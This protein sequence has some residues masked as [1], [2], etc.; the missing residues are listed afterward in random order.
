MK[1]VTKYR[2][3]TLMCEF[4]LPVIFLR[5]SPNGFLPGFGLDFGFEC[6]LA[7]EVILEPFLLFS[8][9]TIFRRNIFIKASRSSEF[10]TKFFWL[11]SELADWVFFTDRSD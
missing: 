9:L 6:D 8:S 10:R 5:F 7:A 11:F 4:P 3:F 2:S 1:S